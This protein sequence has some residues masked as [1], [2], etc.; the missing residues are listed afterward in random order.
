VRDLYGTVV[1]EGANK[2]IL[3]TTSDFGPDSYE[4]VKG[5]PIRLFSGGE[6]VHLL[7][8]HGHKARID[9]AEAKQIQAEKDAEARR[10]TRS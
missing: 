5:L 4:Y 10:Q 3:I 7:G 1:K 2:G 6:L 9:L 8:K